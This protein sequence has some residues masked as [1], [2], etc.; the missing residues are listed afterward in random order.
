[1]GNRTWSP[2]KRGKSH[3]TI[4]EVGVTEKLGEHGKQQ[5]ATTNIGAMAN[6]S[7][8][9]T[10]INDKSKKL[11]MDLDL[12][13]VNAENNRMDMGV[14]KCVATDCKVIE[15]GILRINA[16]EEVLPIDAMHVT[17]NLQDGPNKQKPK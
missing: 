10:S 13:E 8:Q 3:L 2:P 11:A 16:V 4:S 15:S 5:T 1:M 12:R 9:E 7:T 6:P 14:T 17:T